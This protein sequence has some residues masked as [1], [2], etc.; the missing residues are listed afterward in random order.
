MPVPATTTVNPEATEL[1]SAS[2]RRRLE[3]SW[4]TSW[5]YMSWKESHRHR[6]LS[7]EVAPSA[8][9][10]VL[11]TVTLR[12]WEKGTTAPV[13]EGAGLVTARATAAPRAVRV[14]PMGLSTGTSV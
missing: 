3:E 11:F 1:A 9:S 10:R 6:V 14:A 12:L 13:R 7:V 4:A 8:T 5:K 2:W